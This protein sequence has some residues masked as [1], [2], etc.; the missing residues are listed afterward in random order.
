MLA[1][2]PAKPLDEKTAAITIYGSED[3]VLNMKKM[4]Y[5]KQYLPDGSKEYVI[6]GGNHSQFGNYGKQDGDGIADIS[7]DEQQH[8]T[9]ELILQIK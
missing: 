2:Y 3:G 1:A 5:A 9:V 4:T 6:K 8:K 7:S